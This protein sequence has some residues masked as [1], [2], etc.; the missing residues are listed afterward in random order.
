MILRVIFYDKFQHNYSKLLLELKNFDFD[1]SVSF[2]SQNIIQILST[3]FDNKQKEDNG[4]RN[5]FMT[6]VNEHYVAGLGLDLPNPCLAADCAREPGS[7]VKEGTITYIWNRASQQNIF[8]I[9]PVNPLNSTQSVPAWLCQHPYQNASG[10]FIYLFFFYRT[11]HAF[12][13]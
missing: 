4:G 10:L 6:N 2:V 12:L 13:S 11:W 7:K 8:I 5:N 3:V 9:N 1:C